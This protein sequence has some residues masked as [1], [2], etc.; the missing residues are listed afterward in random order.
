M[1]EQALMKYTIGRWCSKLNKACG[2]SEAELQSLQA[3]LLTLEA[4]FQYANER[5]GLEDNEKRLLFFVRALNSQCSASLTPAL[6]KLI[7]GLGL[8]PA[9]FKSGET[10]FRRQ[11]AADLLFKH[12]GVGPHLLLAMGYNKGE[13]EEAQQD[14]FNS[15]QASR[16]VNEEPMEAV[17]LGDVVFPSYD[18]DSLFD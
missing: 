5:L 12:M 15:R 13:I 6:E 11:R 2:L 14:R 1:S 7:A 4:D 10:Q 17:P 3:H 9:M 8:N 16:R 18:T